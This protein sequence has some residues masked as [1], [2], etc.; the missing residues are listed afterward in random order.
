[1][2]TTLTE[3]VQQGGPDANLLLAEAC[4]VLDEARAGNQPQIQT[5]P[6]YSV[7]EHIRRLQDGVEIKPAKVIEEANIPGA[8]SKHQPGPPCPF[9]RSLLTSTLPRQ[10][11]KAD[12]SLLLRRFG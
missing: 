7:V 8:A 1:M 2:K 9:Q 10:S 4:A 3:N 6:T 5:L 12:S 11:P